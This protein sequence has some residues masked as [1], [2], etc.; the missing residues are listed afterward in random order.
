MS[1]P[2]LP[3]PVQP[4]QLSPRAIHPEPSPSSARI[5]VVDDDPILSRLMAMLLAGAGYQVD[6]AGDGEQGWTA[7][8]TKSYDLLMTD[9]D[10]PRLKGLGLVQRLRAAGMSLPV[11][12]VSGSEHIRNFVDDA[13]LALA[14]VMPKPFNPQDLVAEVGR[15]C[16]VTAE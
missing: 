6:T 16:H 10:M 3:R 5:L 14:A 9:N 13:F 7:L 8:N 15:A 4:N 1:G 2:I 11:I 12:V